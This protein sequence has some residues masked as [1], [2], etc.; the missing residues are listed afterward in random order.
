M[1]IKS[2]LAVC[3]FLC[4]V[5][6]AFT[7]NSVT[8]VK[9][10]KPEAVIAISANGNKT[11]SF[12]AAELQKYIEQITG[13]KLPVLKIDDSITLKAFI[14]QNKN[15]LLVGE[16][17]YAMELGLTA[18]DLKEDGYKIATKENTV[19]I[20]G[21][22][23]GTPNPLLQM[24]HMTD[25]LGNPKFNVDAVIGS[26]GT[27]YG[28]YR[29]LEELGVRWFYPGKF[30]E[31]VPSQNN[32]LIKDMNIKMEPYFKYR[33]V[34]PESWP[35][36]AEN[37]IWER[38][39]GFG[40]GEAT[41]DT[42][43]H[44]FTSWT[45]KYQ[46]THPEYFALN[47]PVPNF[48]HI[49]FS[50]P[51]AREQMLQDVREFFISHPDPVK[52]PYFCLTHNDGHIRTCDCNLC[53]SK[54]IGTNGASGT[55]SQIV[56]ET[57]IYLAEKIKKEFPDRGI[58]IAAYNN[59]LRPPPGI[60]R[61]PDNVSVMIAKASRLH[62]WSEDNKKNLRDIIE[63][64]QKLKPREIFLWEYYDCD[65]DTRTGVPMLAP[66]FI[67]EDMAYLKK[68]SA[69]AP[70]IKGEAIFAV[71]FNP[72]NPK[73][74]EGRS[75]W[76][77]LNYYITSKLLWDP[78]LNVD[79]L[80]NDYFNKFY[81]P[82][83]LPVKQYFSKTEETWAKGNHVMKSLYGSK[84]M[85]A[86]WSYRKQ[87][88]L[89]GF[90]QKPWQNLF[91]ED[92]MAELAKCLDDAEKIAKGEP[93]KNRVAFLKKGFAYMQQC[94]DE[95][96]HKE[97][98]QAAPEIVIPKVDNNFKFETDNCYEQFGEKVSFHDHMTGKTL[99]LG[100]DAYLLYDQDYLYINFICAK[101]PAEKCK[102]TK[103][104]RDWPIWEDESVEIFI[105]SDGSRENFYHIIVNPLGISAEI[106]DDSN[107]SWNPELKISAREE[108]NQWKVK[109]G[110]PFKELKHIPK[111]GDI[112]YF[113]ICRNRYSGENVE[114]QSLF[115]TGKSF[116]T[117][118]KFGRLIFSDKKTDKAIIP[119]KDSELGAW[120]FDE[121][122]GTVAHDSSDNKH[123]GEIRGNA[124]KT[125]G[126][127][128]GALS[129]DGVDSQVIFKS[130]NKK[131]NLI[132]ELDELTVQLWIH[133]QLK[134]SNIL[135]I[136]DNQM[137]LHMDS[138]AGA[139]FYLT[140]S[141][142]EKSGYVNYKNGA[143]KLDEWNYIAATYDGKLMKLYV[144]AELQNSIPFTGKI[145]KSYNWLILGSYFNDNYPSFEGTVDEL[146]ILK[147]ALNAEEIK[148]NF[149][150]H[151]RSFHN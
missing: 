120:R 113:N 79:D 146:S 66:H 56:V 23:S 76:F 87:E 138:K 43:I 145:S 105:T 133:P 36:T 128:G 51:A 139:G 58:L 22:D 33:A 81:G 127:S 106:D 98:Q 57:A 54:R 117:P 62:Y 142:G 65:S 50:N 41:P 148:N 109:I 64:W 131:A 9:D 96:K 35:Y 25:R 45:K 55:D 70:A 63:G 135:R 21:R 3:V 26:M 132:S 119:D 82:A 114:Y 143:I 140:N 126:V 84:D 18:K 144:N 150:Y 14:S 67:S 6:N 44:Y 102:V 1:R 122:S 141:K 73:Q 88:K 94:A 91:T 111:A 116:H 121:T 151:K 69:E 20:L 112:W 60:D 49:C 34:W 90:V 68:L 47:G 40:L 123:D 149:D 27:L 39:I 28:T 85:P 19:I 130:D 129:L 4:L 80:L 101:E 17:K 15:V 77:D 104:Q 108:K 136:S 124:A 125:N 86:N 118:S 5:W 103:T 37:S 16:N 71:N 46:Q 59:Y 11:A 13:A 29:F 75:W 31:V 61:L 78:S 115:P 42:T 93:Y 12:A 83:A 97:Q 72:L 52:Y 8:L 110:I 30:G 107:Y 134:S 2:Y 100:T 95:K 32:I 7:E 10:G 48:S 147:K 53:G 99:A 74:I 92:V 24:C 137:I 89:S 38:R